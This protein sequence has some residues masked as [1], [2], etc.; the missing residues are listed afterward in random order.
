MEIRMSLAETVRPTHPPRVPHT[1]VEG[2]ENWYEP[3][4]VT[5]EMIGEAS[6]R[7]AT[8]RKILA[9]YGRLS[10]DDYTSSLVRFCSK[11]LDSFGDDWRYSDIVTAL[12]AA[13]AFIKPASY[14]EIGVRRGRSMAVV[15]SGSPNCSIVGFDNWKPGYAGMENPG[16]D[17]VREEMKRIGHSGSLEL[18]KGNSHETVPAYLA[19]HP[20]A[21]FDLITV[22]GD[23][24]P[25]GAAEDLATVLARLKIGGA[26]VF[27]DI[28]HPQ[29]REL[30]QVWQ[31][32]VG[33]QTGFSLWNYTAL[34]YGIGIAVRKR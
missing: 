22:D 4:V 30:A 19:A 9:L 15:A 23:H 25:R 12:H 29:H 13:T 26:I 6:C 3:V 2:V 16:P 20:S 34:G 21:W 10:S 8:V 28:C 17:F 31:D 5:A 32:A 18:V 33:D 24:T 11:G 14:L 27:D 7:A 1:T